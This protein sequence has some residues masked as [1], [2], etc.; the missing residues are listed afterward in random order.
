MR[1]LLSLLVLGI[2]GA[3]AA[4]S[5]T[6]TN[7]PGR[8]SDISVRGSSILGDRVG[9]GGIYLI[10]TLDGS[11]AHGKSVTS[12]GSTNGIMM[13]DSPT[14]PGP[15][16]KLSFTQTGPTS[17]SFYAEVGPVQTTFAGMSMPFDFGKQAVSSFRFNGT[18]YLLGG[19]PNPWRQGSAGNYRDIPTPFRVTDAQGNLLGYVGV[20]STTLPTTW[21]EVSGGFGTVRVDVTRSSHYGN[22]HFYNHFGTNNLELGFGSMKKGETAFVEGMIQVVPQIWTYKASTGLFHQVGRADSG[23]W[24]ASKSDP[25]NKYLCYGPYEDEAPAGDYGAE[26]HLM[27]DNVTADNKA[28]VNLDVYDANSGCVLASQ[29]LTRKQFKKAN[30]YQAFTLAF[31]APSKARLE[32]RTYFLGGAYVREEKVTLK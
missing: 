4:Q 28:I 7:A 30:N 21:A 29:K 19:V 26:F 11:D 27:L 14:I 15:K 2:C 16:F 25:A 8:M 5:V 12:K 6:F 1:K 13:S 3:A 20:A 24:S 32:F 22:L 9:T 18:R 23:G 10:G 17:V 31:T